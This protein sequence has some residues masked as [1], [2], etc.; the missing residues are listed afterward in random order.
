MGMS[1]GC[2]TGTSG[3]RGSIPTGEFKD[4]IGSVKTSGGMMGESGKG[5]GG[6]SSLGGA[7]IWIEYGGGPK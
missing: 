3:G 2:I 6:G 7:L 5:G 1:G 4:C